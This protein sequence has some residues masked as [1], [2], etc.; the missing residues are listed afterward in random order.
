VVL[1]ALDYSSLLPLF[2]RQDSLSSPDGDQR[3]AVLLYKKPDVEYPLWYLSSTLYNTAFHPVIAYTHENVS[4]IIEIND[5]H[6]F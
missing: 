5:S 4:Y 3:Y 1:Y 2:E 6:R